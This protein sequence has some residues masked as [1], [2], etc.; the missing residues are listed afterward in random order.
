M[1]T[2]KCISAELGGVIRRNICYRDRAVLGKLF[3][4]R[5]QQQGRERRL[6]DEISS[7]P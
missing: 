2:R 5:E 6:R 3:A 7:L 1:M 4:A